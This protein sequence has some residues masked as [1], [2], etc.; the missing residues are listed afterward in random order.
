MD[1]GVAQGTSNYGQTP[2]LFLL[3]RSDLVGCE[4]H[5]GAIPTHSLDLYERLRRW[6]F[7]SAGQVPAQLEMT[8]R[9]DLVPA[10]RLVKLENLV[11]GGFLH[12]LIMEGIAEPSAG[13]R[14]G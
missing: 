7:A 2:V 1:L 4:Q 9:A 14:H 11:Q 8:H 13:W 3:C 12:D 5:D 6:L 10:S